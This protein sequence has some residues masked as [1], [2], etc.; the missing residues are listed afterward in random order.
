MYQLPQLENRLKDERYNFL[1][2]IGKFYLVKRKEKAMRK[3]TL[4]QSVYFLLFLVIISNPLLVKVK[5][6]PKSNQGTIPST[7]D[8]LFGQDIAVNLTLL[9][10]YPSEGFSQSSGFAIKD[11]YTYSIIGKNPSVIDVSTPSNPSL[12]GEYVV[13]TNKY[14]ALTLQDDCLFMGTTDGL[15]ILNISKPNA[16]TLVCYYNTSI[17]DVNNLVVE[18]D[19]AYLAGMESGL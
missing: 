16:I 3:N 2:I 10:S 4:H 19:Y 1:Y 14:N 11:N 12:V 9:G 17:D 8:S 15:E 13:A 18:G 6:T 5:P 7:D